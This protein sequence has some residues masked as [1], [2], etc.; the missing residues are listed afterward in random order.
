MLYFHYWL[1]RDSI[2]PHPSLG[3]ETNRAATTCNMIVA[4]RWGEEDNK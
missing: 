1:D 4:L 2:T 3:I